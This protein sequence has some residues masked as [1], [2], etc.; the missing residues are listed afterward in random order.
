[1]ELQEARR[2][3]KTVEVPDDSGKA[4]SIKP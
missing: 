4:F 2:V 1:M 3:E